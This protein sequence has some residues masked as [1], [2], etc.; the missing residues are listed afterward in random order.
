[1]NLKPLQDRVLIKRLESEQK[2]AGG[3]IIPDSAKEKPMKGV[4]AAAGPG[5]EKAPMSVKE[6]DVV[7]FAKYAGNEL[8]IDGDDFIIMREEEILAVVE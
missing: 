7:L 8:S 1:M 5:K 3:I 6:G 4:V 2:T